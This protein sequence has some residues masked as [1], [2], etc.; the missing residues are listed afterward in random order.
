MKTLEDF[1]QRL[2]ELELEFEEKKKALIVEYCKT[3]AIFKV[4]DVVTDHIGS[5]LVEKVQAAYSF[6]KPVT[7]YRGRV[8]KKD[9]TP[10]KREEKRTVWSSNIPEN[11]PKS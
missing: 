9:G 5:I 7:V 8:L 1:N 6:N 10:T 3:N 4:G 11:T 2:K